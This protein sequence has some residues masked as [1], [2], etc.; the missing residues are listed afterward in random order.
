MKKA[1]PLCIGML[2]C[3]LMVGG[4]AAACGDKLILVGRG[5]RPRSVRPAAQ[6]ASILVYAALGGSL[7]AALV[8]GGLQKGLESAGHRLR[9]VATAEELKRALGTGGFDLV[10]ADFKTVSQVEAQV[11]QAPAHPTVLPTLY[12][13]SPAELTAAQREFSCV[14]TSPAKQKD[15]L[16]VVDQALATRTRQAKAEKK[17]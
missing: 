5:L 11:R 15:Y 16:A 8:E 7:P 13:P 14:V 4:D 3:V 9:T 2:G 12:N 1:L 6:R 10:F 17:Q